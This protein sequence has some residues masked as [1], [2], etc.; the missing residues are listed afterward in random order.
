MITQR[1]LTPGIYLVNISGPLNSRQAEHLSRC[2]QDLYVR[3]IDRV[4]VNLAE[5]PFMDGPGL[6]A[7]V[8]GYK[9]FS[10]DHS[11]QL[12]GLQDQPRL[13]LELT[14][15]EHIFQVLDQPTG[16]PAWSRQT[17]S[18]YPVSML[19]PQMSALVDMAA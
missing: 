4:I 19:T 7:L 11:F 5:A 15:F 16:T 12:V 10:R 17:W 2:F 1:E 18:T 13:V 3:D 6:S 8:S 14:G 9:L